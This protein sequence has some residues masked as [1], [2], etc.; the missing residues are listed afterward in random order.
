M[1]IS[2]RATIFRPFA[3]FSGHS[4]TEVEATRLTD[5]KIELDE[6]TRTEVDRQPSIQLEHI[7]EQPEITV[8]WFQPDERKDGGAYLT[9]TGRLKKLDEIQR[10]LVLTDGTKI[11]LDDV[12]EIE[13]N[14]FQK[15]G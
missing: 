11:P 10:V 8:T 2:Q 6:D 7:S 14:W 3:A 13:S 5:Q 9:A 1:P 4:I 15:Q 12:A